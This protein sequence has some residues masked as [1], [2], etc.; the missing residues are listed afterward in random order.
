MERGLAVWTERTQCFY[1][2]ATVRAHG[3]ALI[4]A[5]EQL[6]ALDGRRALVYVDP[7]AGAPTCLYTDAKEWTWQRDA[8]VLDTGEKVLG[9]VLYDRQG[10][11]C[12]TDR[13][14]QSVTCW[15]GYAFTFPGGDVYSREAKR[16]IG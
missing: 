15:Y 10:V 9:G 1:P 7:A 2:T 8:L 6:S 14:M 13:P 16:R 11:P 3:N 5:D 4:D 12:M